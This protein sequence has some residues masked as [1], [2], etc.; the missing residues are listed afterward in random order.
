MLVLKRFIGESIRLEK[1]G[2]VLARIVVC[3]VLKQGVK[4]GIQAEKEIAIIRDSR[5]AFSTGEEGRGEGEV[6]RTS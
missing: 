6:V 5:E 3:D 1:D 2:K 4:L